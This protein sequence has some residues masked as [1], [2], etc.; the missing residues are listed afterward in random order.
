MFRQLERD[1]TEILPGQLISIG[2]T[3]AIHNIV[4]EEINIL[5]KNK[6]APVL[7]ISLVPI[8]CF[9]F[10]DSLQSWNLIRSFE[11]IA[12]KQLCI[13]ILLFEFDDS[14][15]MGSLLEQSPL[16]FIRDATDKIIL[17]S[18]GSNDVLRLNVIK[19]RAG[20]IGE[21]SFDNHLKKIKDIP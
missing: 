1:L 14:I 4:M 2:H 7:P 13:I 12:K 19:N 18:E 9:E 21:I 5:Q 8:T 16:D 6:N 3:K 11:A 17:I 20:N 10:Q 15:S